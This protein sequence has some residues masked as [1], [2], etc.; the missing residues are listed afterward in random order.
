MRGPC[1][2]RGSN[3]RL[4]VRLRV[5]RILTPG[6]VLKWYNDTPTKDQLTLSSLNV[7]SHYSRLH[8]RLRIRLEVFI[9]QEEATWPAAGVRTRW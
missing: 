8:I 6:L 4:Y 5:Q 9:P 2:I 1:V 7:A 3:I